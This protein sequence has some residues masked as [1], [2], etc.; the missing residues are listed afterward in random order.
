VSARWF[1]V[2]GL[3]VIGV[4]VIILNYAAIIPDGPTQPWLWVGIFCLVGALVAAIG[5]VLRR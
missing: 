4:A 1:G 3:A 5:L 2:T